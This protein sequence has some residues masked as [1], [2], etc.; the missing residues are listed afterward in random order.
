MARRRTWN[1]GPRL[2][3]EEIMGPAKL[4]MWLTFYDAVLIDGDQ[5]EIRL[6]VLGAVVDTWVVIG[7][8]AALEKFEELRPQ[9]ATLVARIALGL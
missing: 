2:I 6:S 1:R 8:R 5:Y 4:T 3:A 7:R 9:M